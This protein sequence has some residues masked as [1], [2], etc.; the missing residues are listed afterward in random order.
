MKIVD[1]NIDDLRP[2][3]RNPRRNDSS[4][5]AVA[6]SIKEFG[7]KVP[8]VVTSDGEIVAGHTRYKAAKLLR[9]DTVP[10][11][12]AEDLTPEQIAAYRLAD[13]KAGEKS[14][15]DIALLDEELADIEGIDMAQFGFSDVMKDIDSISYIDDLMQNEFSGGKAPD[16]QYF[17]VTFTFSKE[18]E[19]MVKTYIKEHGKEELV[20]LMLEHMEGQN[21]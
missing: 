13:N 7:F 1:K 20:Y 3:E 16:S 8:L 14:V 10:C 15:W 6:A 11:I 9:L 19:R 4:V 5:E 21:A 12:V 18:H 17:D 2:Y